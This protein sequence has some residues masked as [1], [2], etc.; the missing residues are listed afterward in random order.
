MVLSFIRVLWSTPSH[1]GVV[2]VRLGLRPER[3][4]VGQKE[5]Q[6]YRSA[7]GESL[8]VSFSVPLLMVVAEAVLVA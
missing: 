4:Q 8:L 5:S 3:Q 1:S 7:R 2:S 6:R